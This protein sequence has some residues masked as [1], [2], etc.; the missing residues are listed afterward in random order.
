MSRELGMQASLR[1][2]ALL[3][4]LSLLLGG[5]V[6][7]AQEHAKAKVRKVPDNLSAEEATAARVYQDALPAVVTIAARH[8]SRDG[9]NSEGSLGTGVL[10][11]PDCHVLTAAHVVDGAEEILVK[12][13]DGIARPAVH[14]FSEAG[15]DIAL[16]RLVDP[17]LSLAHAKL[18]D[19]DRLSVGQWA[20]AIGTPFGLENSFSAGRI[21]GFREF[22]RLYD[23]TILAEFIQTDATLNSGS[24]G[25]PV[26]NSSGEVIGIASRIFSL[27][28]GSEGI[29]FAVAI[30]T[31]KQLLALEDR[32]WMGFDAA[33]L[34]SDVLGRFF[35]LDVEGGM[36]V[37]QVVKGSPADKAGLRGGTIKATIGG[38]EI[39]LGGDLILAMGVQE[40]CHLECLVRTR[41]S[42][43]GSDEIKVRFLRG[44]QEMVAVVD[45]SASRRNFLE[46]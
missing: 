25:G 39:L 1:S 5:E 12:T 38:Q 44:G 31:A 26:F 7:L 10:I 40:S 43:A 2:P 30:N 35:N 19:S 21:S 6:L 42:L 15:A 27:S 23:G 20:Y 37:Q 4:T 46:P 24:S 11:S 13:Q 29:G 22:D 3:C 9:K 41:Q 32:I 45:V 28:G 14:I 18:G 17:D 33:F 8:A 36:L 34:E 16:L